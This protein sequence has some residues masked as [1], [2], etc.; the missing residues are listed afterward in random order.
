MLDSF[1][2]RTF[3][4]QDEIITALNRMDATASA[5][6]SNINNPNITN[7]A[8]FA[9]RT[10]INNGAFAFLNTRSPNLLNKSVRQAIR[11]GIDID[12]LRKDL[13]DD[14]ALDFPILSSQ[15]EL[16]LPKL[17]TFDPEKSAEL[18]TSAGFTFTEDGLLLDSEGEQPTLSIV[19]IS[20]GHLA[21]LAGRL[22][23]QLSELGFNATA[24]IYDTENSTTGNFFVSVIRPRD[25]DI[26]LYEI[27]MGTDPDL[28]PYY[29]SSQASASGF[30]FSD[31]RSGIV[32]D[33]L[34]S[35]RTSFDLPLRRAKYESFLS[36]WIDDVPAIGLYRVNLTYYFNRSARTFSENSRLSSPFD[37]FS[38]VQYWATEKGMRYRTP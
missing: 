24:E 25:Y 29:H 18:L 28:F 35:A 34:R 33:L 36:H 23:K 19:T 3:S 9:K 27:D 31:Y 26:L 21:E 5:D 15:I 2:L 37:R 20:D 10:A 16:S 6:L 13:V 22:A 38:D 4:S 11:H 30:N 1:T 14:I 32:D 8:V 12:A 17:P 7:P